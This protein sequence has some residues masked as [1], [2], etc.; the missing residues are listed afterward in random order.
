M[1]IRGAGDADGD[2]PHDLGSQA[3]LGVRRARARRAARAS[4][5]ACGARAR[6]LN[7]VQNMKEAFERFD[8]KED[9]VLPRREQVKMFRMIEVRPAPP[10]PLGAVLR[11][12]RG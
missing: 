10:P 6:H 7:T 12:G 3:R 8:Y 1:V 9:D 2:G 4:F 11:A 5:H